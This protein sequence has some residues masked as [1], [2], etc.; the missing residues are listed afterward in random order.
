MRSC[1]GVCHKP[2]QR[3]SL[4][5][6]PPAP[7]WPNLAGSPSPLKSRG[8]ALG[9]GLP[10]GLG[11]GGRWKRSVSS[12][13]PPALHTPTPHS[14]Y[15]ISRQAQYVSIRTIFG[16]YINDHRAKAVHSLASPY[17][18]IISLFLHNS[19]FSL[20]LMTVL[21]S[22]LLCV[23]WTHHQS[24]PAP[25]AVHISSPDVPAPECHVKFTFPKN[26]LL[27]SQLRTGVHAG[28][29]TSS[30]ENP[31]SSGSVLPDSPPHCLS[32]DSLKYVR[33]EL[34]RHV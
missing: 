20:E 28:L 31:V 25:P 24:S 18:I 30:Q 10:H 21:C 8:L 26:S 32:V 27:G 5:R 19:L 33:R 14:P 7:G 34:L 23:P 4:P 12:T 3:L 11:W 29:P 13:R 1:W 17:T 6:Y 9:Q 2:Q 22:H 16:V 15:T